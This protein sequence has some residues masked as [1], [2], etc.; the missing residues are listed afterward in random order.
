MSIEKQQS[1]ST[2]NKLEL[3]NTLLR[4]PTRAIEI[5]NRKS[6]QRFTLCLNFT[7]ELCYRDG[8]NIRLL[9]N[10]NDF[11][12]VEDEA[13]AVEIEKSGTMLSVSTAPD[14]AD[15]CEHTVNGPASIPPTSM[16][17][18]Q[19]I[20]RFNTMVDGLATRRERAAAPPEQ[21][22]ESSEPLMTSFRVSVPLEY[23]LN[24]LAAKYVVA[25]TGSILEMKKDV[26]P[27]MKFPVGKLQ[28]TGLVKD[29][30]GLMPMIEEALKAA[31][32]SYDVTVTA[33]KYLRM[34]VWMKI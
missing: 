6:G 2:I 12:L 4:D 10:T 3:V 21:K 34:N 31:G 24:D 28:T 33:G 32:Y 30:P 27:K 11:E 29:I 13:A 20:R 7:N 15:K 14:D 19:W 18:V 9:K 1:A 5:I 26:L 23:E 25:I 22:K 16:D 8:N 17:I